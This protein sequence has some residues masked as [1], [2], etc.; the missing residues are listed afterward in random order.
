MKNPHASAPYMA[1]AMQALSDPA[2]TKIDFMARQMSKQNKAV[3]GAEWIACT[4]RLP[5][6]GVTVETKIDNAQGV[7]NFARLKRRGNLWFFEDG[8]IYVYYTPTHWR[9]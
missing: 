1:G 7:R 3:W 5:P 8:S 9:R 4:S 6:N 2:I